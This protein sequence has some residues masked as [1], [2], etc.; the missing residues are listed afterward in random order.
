[1]ADNFQDS[2]EVKMSL[3]HDLEKLSD[4]QLVKLASDRSSAKEK[5]F[6]FLKNILDKF[7]RNKFALR[8]G[9]REPVNGAEKIELKLWNQQITEE[10]FLTA[11]R[12]YANRPIDSE[13]LDCLERDLDSKLDHFST[14]IHSVLDAQTLCNRNNNITAGEANE[15]IATQQCSLFY[16]KSSLFKEELLTCSVFFEEM[17][18]TDKKG[19]IELLDFSGT[20]AWF[21]SV[22]SLKYA[23]SAWYSCREIAF[24]SQTTLEYTHAE[25]ACSLFCQVHLQNLP[26]PQQLYSLVTEEIS[27]AR[28]RL[29][30]LNLDRSVGARKNELLEC[31]C[32]Q[33]LSILKNMSLLMEQMPSSFSETSEED[34]RTHFL[35][36][37]NGIW[38]GQ[39]T[40]E[41]INGNGKTDI[42]VRKGQTN[43]VI[44]ECKF[45]AGPKAHLKTIDQIMNY[46]TWRDTNLAILVFNR[47][48]NF[49][50]M[51]QSMENTTKSHPN[52]LN[53]LEK[54]SETCFKYTF[55]SSDDSANEIHL[56]V[57]AFDVPA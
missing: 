18:A 11:M 24:K 49:T 28:V 36:Q 6:P 27:R 14:F 39:A 57:L 9:L 19:T 38:P 54:S 12:D 51:L 48:R 55:T 37:L 10:Q 23:A 3:L 16:G 34:I 17:N 33:I 2:F 20:T 15:K 13:M 44:I 53:S 4:D 40:G 56:T 35:V 5:A 25:S 52:F 45:W 26:K 42:L 41:T 47:Q 8:T 50:K 1:M 32:E 22:L 21:V 29:Q 30:K 43:I 31:N 46:G 7:G